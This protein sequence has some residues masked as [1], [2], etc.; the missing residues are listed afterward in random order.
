[1]TLSAIKT[2]LHRFRTETDGYATIEVAIM[3]PILFVLFGAAW[4]YFDVFRQQSI[5]IKFI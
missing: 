2:R 1:M 4:V 3:I 5:N